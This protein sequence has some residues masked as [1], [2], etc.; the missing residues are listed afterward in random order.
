MELGST[1][2]CAQAGRHRSFPVQAPGRSPGTGRGQD[3]AGHRSH[4]VPGNG[5]GTVRVPGA[6]GAHLGGQ[7]P[8]QPTHGPG[9]AEQPR[10]VTGA[11]GRA[12][13]GRDQAGSGS[14]K[15]RR[16]SRCPRASCSGTGPL[17]V[18]LVPCVPTAPGLSPAA[19]TGLAAHTRVPTHT[20]AQVCTHRHAGPQQAPPRGISQL[21]AGRSPPAAPPRPALTFAQTPQGGRG[22]GIKSEPGAAPAPQSPAQVSGDIPAEGRAGMGTGPV[23]APSW[24]PCCPTPCALLSPQP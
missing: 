24:P 1:R 8:A 20:H 16:A 19:G 21:L 18:T 5:A 12:R 3:T 6:L 13:R 11:K 15:V 2:G 7:P 17:D 23:S 4:T 14:G 9:A 10:C 22:E